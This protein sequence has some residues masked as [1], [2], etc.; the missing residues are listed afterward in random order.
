MRSCPTVCAM[1]FMKVTTIIQSTWHM[2]MPDQPAVAFFLFA[3]SALLLQN[4]SFSHS[5]TDR[6]T[7]RQ[8][9][10]IMMP[11]AQK[12]QPMGKADTRVSSYAH[13]VAQLTAS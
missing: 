6:Q 8:T 4:I 1:C 5:V 3:F 10:N 11:A 2:P 7:D 12:P 9:D 13:T